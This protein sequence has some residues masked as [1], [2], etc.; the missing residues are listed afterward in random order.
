MS[1]ERHAYDDPSTP[2]E[3]YD[4]C[5]AVGLK[6]RY[7]RIAKAANR[8]APS[9]RFEDFPADVP[10]REVEI[11]DAASRLADAIYGT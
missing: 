10:K 7:D 3:M 1:S 9:L 5:R 6:L 8:P 2:H 4:D 11:S